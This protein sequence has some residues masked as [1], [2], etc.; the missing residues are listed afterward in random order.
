MLDFIKNSEMYQKFQK[1]I[2]YRVVVLTLLVLV[3]FGFDLGTLEVVGFSLGFLVC[4]ALASHLL[5]KALFP[6][7]D[8]SK[9][10]KAVEKE[11]LASA[12]AILAVCIVLSTLI[13]S[14]SSLWIAR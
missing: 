12:V 5:R 8:I 3:L 14:A 11:A 6:Y 10:F 4:Q 7:L 1:H 13:H 9:L 2:G